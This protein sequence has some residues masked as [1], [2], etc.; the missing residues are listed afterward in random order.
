MQQFLLTVAVALVVGFAADWVRIRLTRTR[1]EGAIRH[2]GHKWQH[3][4]FEV[5]P[6]IITFE[7]YRWHVRLRS[8]NKRNILVIKVDDWSGQ[9]PS[10]REWWSIN[11]S[12]QII[13]L[14]TPDGVV[15]FAA[16]PNML[17]TVRSDLQ[18]NARPLPL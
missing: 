8:G 11:N 1:P 12:V 18:V 7:P 5:T 6:G 4:R 14:T 3:G 9:A 10:R 16:L 2:T 17:K 15:Q 13:E